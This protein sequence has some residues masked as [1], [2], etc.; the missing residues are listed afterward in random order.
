ME[1]AENGLSDARANGSGEP[2]IAAIETIATNSAAAAKIAK[3]CHQKRMRISA[4]YIARAAAPTPMMLTY[5]GNRSA[6]FDPAQDGVCAA[7]EPSTA[8]TERI[9][10]PL[11]LLSL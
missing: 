6:A 3:T 8:S 1:L 9:E 4:R 7:I 11:R 10:R 2:C 5:L